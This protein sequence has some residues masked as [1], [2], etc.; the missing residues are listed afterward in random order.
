MF[1]TKLRVYDKDEI[2]VQAEKLFYLQFFALHQNN[3]IAV[4]G[5]VSLFLLIGRFSSFENEAYLEFAT[6]ATVYDA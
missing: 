4:C 3:T 5:H 2:E 1:V 6:F